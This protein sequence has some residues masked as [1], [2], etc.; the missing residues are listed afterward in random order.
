M[1]ENT[2]S[3]PSFGSW[4]I[5]ILLSFVWGSSFILI[6][7][8][9]IAFDPVEV[10]ALRVVI[11]FFA[12]LPVIMYHRKSIDWGD[13]KKFLIVGIMGSALPSVLFAIAQTQ[14][15][16]SIAGV[17]NSI[18]PVFTLIIGIIMFNQTA[19]RNQIIGV[20]FGFV[21][22]LLLLL[23]DQSHDTGTNLL[24]GMLVVLATICYAFNVN[25]IKAWFNNTS[26]II[27]SA[28]S[29]SMLGPLG[30]IYLLNTSF[31]EQLTTHEHGWYSFGAVLFLALVGTAIS[32]ILFFKLIQ[33]T[34]A[35]FGS[36]VAFVIPIFAVLW[37]LFDGESFYLIQLI[38]MLLVLLGVYLIRDKKKKT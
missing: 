31:I 11:T 37:G 2:T 5:L 34:N 12:F 4:A 13:W 8:S 27:I 6:K 36:S 29:F 9:L 25:S 17:L 16:S 38:G 30:I 1:Q 20:A 14:V 33:D 21:G 28:V 23:G 32:T 35:I 26:P 22:A 10:G 3:S 15:S 24:Y 18:T 19:K 7:K